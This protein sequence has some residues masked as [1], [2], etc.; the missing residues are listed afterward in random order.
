[1]DNEYE[2]TMQKIIFIIILLLLCVSS[3]VSSSLFGKQFIVFQMI[4]ALFS[5]IF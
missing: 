1:M 2:S 4:S 3:I 5:N